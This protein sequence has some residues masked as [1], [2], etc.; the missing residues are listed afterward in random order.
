LNEWVHVAATFN[1]TTNE[2]KIYLNGI[3]QTITNNGDSITSA[4]NIKRIGGRNNGM[5]IGG[6]LDD[7]RIYDYV[8]TPAQIAWDY[9]RGAPVGHW[10]FDECS[11]D[12]VYDWAPGA[13]PNSFVGNNGTITIG[14][15]GDQDDTGSCTSGDSGD[16]WYNG[17]T[18]KFGSS[19]SF[20]GEDDYVTIADTDA[21]SF[22]DSS[23]DRPFSISAWVNMVDAT[24][25]PIFTKGSSTAREYAFWVESSDYLQM[26]LFD[27]TSS[28]YLSGTSSDTFTTDQGSWVHYTATYD[29]S[30]S[31]NGI[32]LYRNGILL[33][34]AQSSN[35]YTAMH[36]Q[37]ETAVIGRRM[38][39]QSNYSEGKIDDV[40]IFNYALT[41]EQIKMIFN[42]G[43]VR[44][45]P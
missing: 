36:N 21:L 16:A 45:G 37:A 32:N 3:S 41:L 18:G 15:T 6:S 2:G 10:K 1:S 30:S 43:A 25:F 24:A 17:A 29:G 9:N 12:T 40:Q 14:G 8:R 44:F 4:T 28:N 13:G 31:V 20:D 34:T 42:Q 22:G 23:N 39:D 38:N 35:G 27:D 11:G 26:Q 5:Y 7:V 19:L 33:Q